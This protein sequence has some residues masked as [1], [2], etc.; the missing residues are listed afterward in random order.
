M[1]QAFKKELAAKLA[2]LVPRAVLEQSKYLKHTNKDFSQTYYS[3]EGEEIILR[4]YFQQRNTGFFVDIGAHH[5]QKF[6]NTYK[7]YQLG[8]RGVNIDATP[9]SMEIFN[10]LRPKD[11]NLECAISDGVEQLTFYEFDE[12]AL[13][14]FSKEKADV[15]L[16]ESNFKL[17]NTINLK[18]QKL[19]TVLEQHLKENT[20]IDFFSID[21]E[22]L[23]F[24]VLNGNNWN[25]FKPE[26]ILVE[27]SSISLND[28]EKDQTFIYLKHLGY[29]PF[30]KTYKTV[31]YSCK[32]MPNY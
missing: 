30:A 21:V 17:S 12:P 32:S 6:S 27:T 31:F 14:T 23:D 10:L 7:L 9:K 1:W 4:R 28:L 11:I 19:E 16:K 2:K 26:V 8:W 29:Y 18:T 22:G 5:P 25:K 24:K 13:N 3:Q 20:K 15:I